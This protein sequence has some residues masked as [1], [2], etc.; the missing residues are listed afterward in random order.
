MALRLKLAGQRRLQA[1]RAFAARDEPTAQ[2]VPW[3]RWLLHVH[4]C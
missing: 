1:V 2:H 3:R 4:L